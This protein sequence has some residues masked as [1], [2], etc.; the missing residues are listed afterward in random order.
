V[1][2]VFPS[3]GLVAATAIGLLLGVLAALVPARQAAR[4]NI[5]RALRYE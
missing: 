2:F 3:G 4:M 1:A 5:V